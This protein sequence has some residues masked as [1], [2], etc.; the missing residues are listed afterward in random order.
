MN[1][2]QLQAQNNDITSRNSEDDS[3]TDDRSDEGKYMSSAASA[4]KLFK[5]KTEYVQSNNVRN[6]KTNGNDNMKMEEIYKR[7]SGEKFPGNASSFPNSALDYR[8]LVNRCF[9][10]QHPSSPESSNANKDEDDKI[11]EK[12]GN[13]TESSTMLSDRILSVSPMR[14]SRLSVGI[15]SLS[16]TYS[17]NGCVTTD[18]KEGEMEHSTNDSCTTESFGHSSTVTSP[19]TTSSMS[20]YEPRKKKT[21]TVFSRT[22]IYQ[23]ESTFDMK[24]Y[25]SSSER[26]SLARSLNLTETQVRRRCSLPPQ[27]CLHLHL[28]LHYLNIILHISGENLVSEQKK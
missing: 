17:E 20:S 27:F 26:A 18:H 8:K 3:K 11:A 25:L 24:R 12:R 15:S 5:N 10:I 19:T 7:H 4:F 14:C 16:S 2:V 23:L 6:F 22:Q 1:S 28:R 21:R 13:L 9:S